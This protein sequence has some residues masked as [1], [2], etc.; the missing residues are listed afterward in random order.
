MLAFQNVASRLVPL[1]PCGQWPSDVHLWKVAI[2]DGDAASLLEQEILDASERERAAR[3]LRHSDR[4]RF[5]VTRATLRWLL[6]DRVG[7][8]P[9]ALCFASGPYGRPW[10]ADYPDLSFNVSHSGDYALVVISEKRAVGVD[11]E[12]IEEKTDWRSL[13]KV[14]CTE[15]EF[16]AIEQMA[17]VLQVPGFFR[18]WTAKEALLKATGLGIAEN[19]RGL[20]VDLA[21]EDVQQPSIRSERVAAL[22]ALRFRWLT[23]NP[24]YSA[25]VA[26]DA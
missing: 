14:V 21:A 4:A 9:S 1:A 22:N 24:G 19:L 16:V 18:C 26:F 23:I 10:L 7:T 6:A 8:S 20:S 3:Y 11:I 5:V 25:C 2:P 12:R 15:D 13:A 17:P